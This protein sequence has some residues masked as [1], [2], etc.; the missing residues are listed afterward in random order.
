MPGLRVGD[1]RL[2]RPGQT[3]HL[4]LAGVPV[5]RGHQRARARSAPAE[6]SLD[7]IA[8]ALRAMAPTA[9]ELRAL[10]PDFAPA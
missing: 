4:L 7:E 2:A 10:A 5:E 1:R 3:A 8:A 9:D 6:L